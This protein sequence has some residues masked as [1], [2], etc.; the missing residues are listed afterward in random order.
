MR[1]RE[2]GEKRYY[3][4]LDSLVDP[5][6]DFIKTGKL[7]VSYLEEVNEQTAL[8]NFSKAIL[9]GFTSE[10]VKSFFV[11]ANQVFGV[12]PTKE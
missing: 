2:L 8:R 7:E 10:Q 9:Y 5:I 12:P 4:I 1:D 3:L 11:R 6:G